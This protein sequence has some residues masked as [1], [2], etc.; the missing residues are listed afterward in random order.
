[1]SA[2]DLTKFQASMSKTKGNPKDAETLQSYLVEKVAGSNRKKEGM[3]LFVVP[4][5][6]LYNSNYNDW[7]IDIIHFWRWTLKAATNR[8]CSIGC[9]RHL[10]VA[11]I[12]SD[13]VMSS[14]LLRQVVLTVLI[15]GNGWRFQY[16]QATTNSSEFQK[17]PDAH[18]YHGIFTYY[19]NGW[20]L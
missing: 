6:V 15:I 14:Q 9:F 4:L 12:E 1:M 8:Y 19:M 11:L 17:K 5:D 18:M 7:N 10:A 13:G 16:Y 20:C 3:C 2:G